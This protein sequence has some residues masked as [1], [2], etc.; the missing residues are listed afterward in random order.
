MHTG[1]SKTFTLTAT[2]A[3][4]PHRRHY[5]RCQFTAWGTNVV[6]RQERSS[7]SRHGK[8]TVTATYKDPLGSTL[9]PFHRHVIH[10]PLTADLFDPS[11]YATGTLMRLLKT[12]V[13]GV[14]GFVAGNNNGIDISQHKYIVVKLN[15]NPTGGVSVPYVR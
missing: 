2:F 1:A 8:R 4:G 10:V 6:T 14:Y 12:P 13:T 11:I 5:F 15:K 9:T 3:D 7:S